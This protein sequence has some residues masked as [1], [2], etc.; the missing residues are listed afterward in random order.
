MAGPVIPLCNHSSAVLHMNTIFNKKDK[1][2]AHPYTITAKGDNGASSHYLRPED[3]IVL[4]NVTKMD[5][6]IVSLPNNKKSSWSG[7]TS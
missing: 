1:P 6:P 2:V 7:V 3:K 5:G 4:K